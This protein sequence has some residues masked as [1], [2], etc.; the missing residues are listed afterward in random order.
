VTK[1]IL[2]NASFSAA[3]QFANV[4]ISI[5]FVPAYIYFLK[6]EGYGIYSFLMLFFGWITILQAGVDP[7]VIRM[8]AKYVAEKKHININPLITASLMFQVIIA[9]SIGLLVFVFA[10]YLASFIVKNETNFLNE[11]RIALYY[12]AINIVVLMCKNVYLSFYK[13]LQRYD[14]SSVYESIFNL[15]ASLIGLLSLWLGYGIV[16]MIVVR[17]ILN[18]LS[19]ALLHFMARKIVST[20]RLGLNISMGLL[21]EIYD[22][23]SWIVVG[24][25]N[26]LALNA[27]PPIMIGMYIGPSGIAFFNIATKITLSLTNLLAS[28][29]SVIFPFVSEL[30]ALKNAE[31]I[32]LFYME[33]NRILSIISCPLYCFGA[34]YSWD[35]LYIWLGADVANNCWALMA[36]FFV[37][38]YLSSSSMI[39]SNFALGIGNSKILAFTSITQT[40]IVVIFLPYLLNNYGIAGAGINL[41]VFEMASILTGIIITVKYIK[42][43]AITFWL[44]DRIIVLLINI[45]IFSMLSLCKAFIINVPLTRTGI[46]IYL[47]CV[48]FT[49]LS[50]NYF[51]IKYSNLVQKSTKNRLARLA[52]KII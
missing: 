52:Q 27:L 41:I 46:I 25:I 1:R 9:G 38:Y 15:L 18:L 20:F 32:N 26:R 44:R 37:G 4:A 51:I 8:T 19:I 36:L 30:K 45:G 31:K 12:A 35:I 10:D 16:G 23:A 5:V 47:G 48:F 6:I 14:V 33:S 29:I 24:R 34:I 39:P 40:I 21:K 17:L 43:S 13:G 28:S 50:L 7:A 49:G 22:Y 3:S 42:A 2:K 11:T